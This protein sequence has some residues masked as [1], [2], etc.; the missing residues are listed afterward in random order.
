MSIT[1][2][3]EFAHPAKNPWHQPIEV[4]IQLTMNSPHKQ[5][6]LKRRASKS[7][8]PSLVTKPGIGRALI[9]CLALS[10]AVWPVQSATPPI[11]RESAKTMVGHRV[12]NFTL[13][14]LAGRKVALSDFSDKKV[15]A[16]FVMGKGCPVANL[17]LTELMKLQDTYGKKGLQIIG[18]D[19]NSGVTREQLAEQARAFKVTFPVLHDPDQRVA[20]LLRV[21]RTA[22]TLLLDAQRVVRY[23]GRIDD[24]FGYTHKRSQP[25]RRDLQEALDQ[26]LAGEVVTISVTA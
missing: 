7:K 21:T 18:I 22:E 4:Y 3:R 20:Q 25:R 13:T 8:F 19:S 26:V 15:I 10:G 6:Y 5:F 9:V 17:Y 24:R 12:S 2:L 23:Q 11:L 1:R 16:I 14:D